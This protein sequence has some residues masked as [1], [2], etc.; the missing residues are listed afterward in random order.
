MV[1]QR[2]IY[3][4]F[5]A[6]AKKP[7]KKPLLVMGA[8]QIGKTTAI[9]T[10]GEKEFEHLVYINFEKEVDVKDFFTSS[11]DPIKIIHNLSLYSG[12]PIIAGKTLLILDEIQECK[13]ALISLKYFQEE[14][15]EIHII[16]AG[17]LLGLTIGNDRS[18][19]VGKVEFLDM[20][21]M[22]FSEYLGTVAP[23]LF[24]VYHSFAEKDKLEPIPKA[25]FTELSREFKEYT[26][27]G[28]MPEV[29]STFIKT[30]SV[31]EAQKIQDAILRGYHLDFVKHASKTTSTKIQYV[32]NSIPS[33][34]AKENKKFLYK[35]LRSGAR[36]REYE[37]AIQWLVESGLVYKVFRVEKPGIPLKGYEDLSSFKLYLFETGLLIRL[38]NLDP[39]TFIDGKAFFTEFKG[40]IAENTVAQNL[41]KSFGTPPFYWTS[42][43]KA[44]VD[45]LAEVHGN[46]IPIEVK[47]GEQTKAKSL[48][49]FTQKYSPQLRMRISPFNISS[50][51]DFLNLPL[52]FSGDFMK[53][54]K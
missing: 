20:Y 15:P 3:N 54:M 26:L 41:K 53:F 2:E 51:N 13:D 46:C 7:N 29:A 28:G 49:V 43:G 40:S 8:R 36:A 35:T 12:T 45:F 38:A 16:G 23:D 21:P 44:E 47:S 27:F 9:K 32:W 1:F 10:F 33:Q 14:S 25:F 6:W 19:P 24:E 50:T 22:S 11:K 37:E 18:F 30:R 17:S 4:N 52:F 31:K 42:E 34:L 39:S 5:K 48:A